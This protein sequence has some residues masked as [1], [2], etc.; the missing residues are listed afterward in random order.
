MKNMYTVAYKTTRTEYYAVE[1]D[2]EYQ[3]QEIAQDEGEFIERDPE[4]G[5]AWV[6]E[7]ESIDD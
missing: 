1:A 3:A 2:N 7:M 6:V 5:E 4:N